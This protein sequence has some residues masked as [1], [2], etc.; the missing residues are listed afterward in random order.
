MMVLDGPATFVVLMHRLAPER[1]E[2]W[3][4]LAEPIEIAG[5]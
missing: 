5:P 1:D 2:E 4:T 3:H